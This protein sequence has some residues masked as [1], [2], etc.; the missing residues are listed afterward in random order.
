MSSSSCD[1][2][3]SVPNSCLQLLSEKGKY[4]DPAM[5][6]TEVRDSR[7]LAEHVY[8]TRVRGRLLESC[9]CKVSVPCYKRFYAYIPSHLLGKKSWNVYNTANVEKVKADEAKAAAREEAAEQRMQEADAERRIRILRGQ[10]IEPPTA[11]E[12]EEDEPRWK[13]RDDSGRDRKRRRIAGEDDTDREIRFAREDEAVLPAKAEM[14][15]TSKKSSDAPLTDTAGHINLFPSDNQ[16][17]KDFK[18]AEAEADRAKK[19]REY[20]DQYTMRFSNAA[21][22][23]QAI[24]QKPWYEKST[25]HQSLQDGSAVASTDVWGN[26]DPRRKERAKARM[27]SDDPLAIMRN[28]AAGVREAEKQR[29]KWSE[30]KAQEIREIEDDEKRREKRRRGHHIFE[31]RALNSSDCHRFRNRHGRDL[32]RAPH[33]SHRHRSQSQDRDGHRSHRH[34]SRTYH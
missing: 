30:E 2:S 16:S 5:R 29:T 9:H 8:S 32:V 13:G 6:S 20:E 31:D 23:K 7:F 1:Q 4:S 24:D 28:G 34:R 12:K 21:G 14:Q 10:H 17:R 11:H 33:H 25:T 18:N 27:S 22:F 26:E 15:M 19:K 3:I